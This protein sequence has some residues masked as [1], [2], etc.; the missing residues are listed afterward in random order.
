[1]LTDAGI[2]RESLWIDNV[3]PF[4]PPQ[5]DMTYCPKEALETYAQELR[6]RLASLPNLNLVVPMGNTALE[7]LTDKTTISKWRGSLL[8]TCLETSLVALVGPTTRQTKVLPTYH[9]SY[10]FRDPSAMGQAIHDWKRVREE[11]GKPKPVHP[12]MPREFIIYPQQ[13]DLDYLIDACEGSSL[14]SIDIE[15]NMNTREIIC[16]GIAPSPTLACCIPWQRKFFPVIRRIL[17]SPTPKTGHN[18]ALFDNFW[19]TWFGFPVNNLTLDTMFLHHCL[20]PGEGHSLATIASLYTHEIYWKDDA[21]DAKEGTSKKVFAPSEATYLYNCLIPETKVLTGD[22]RWIP[23]GDIQEG[24]ELVGLEEIPSGPQKPRKLKPAYVTRV[25]RRTAEVFCITCE[26]GRKVYATSEHPWLSRNKNWSKARQQWRKTEELKIG[27][28]LTFLADPWETAQDYDS[29]WLAGIL[30]GE[31]SVNEYCVQ[32]AQKQG[33]VLERVKNLLKRKG[34]YYTISHNKESD[35]CAYLMTSLR[36]GMRLLGTLR[37]TR[38]LSKHKRLWVNKSPFQGALGYKVESVESVGEKEVVSIT[39]T[40][41]TFIA[42]G[43]FTHN[44]RDA[45]VTHEIAGLLEAQARRE[46]KWEFYQRHYQAIFPACLATMLGGIRV[47]GERAAE[48]FAE[49]TTRLKEI[50]GQLETLAGKSLIGKKAL[51]NKKKAEFLYDTLKLPKKWTKGDNLSGEKSLA[52]D[53]KTL[54]RLMNANPIALGESGPLLL[55]HARLRQ[56]ST[57]FSPTRIETEMKPGEEGEGRFFFTLK[58]STKTGRLASSKSPFRIGA[59]AQNVDRECKEI[60]LPE[61][62]QLMLELDASQIESRICYM[63]TREP[64]LVKLANTKPWEYD[65]HKE[66]AARIFGILVEA[67]TKEQRHTAKISVH[68]AQRAGTG[69]TLQETILKETGVLRPEKECQALIDSYYKA[70]PG[71]QKFFREVRSQ[72]VTT[73]KI[74]NLWGRTLDFKWERFGEDMFRQA[75]SFEMQSDA[76][77]WLNT[78]GLIPLHDFLTQ[79]HKQSRLLAQVHDSLLLSLAPQEGWEILNFL[80]PLLE[81]PVMYPAGPLSI[82]MEITLGRNWG[83]KA[84]TW[85]KTPTQEEL[86]NACRALNPL[87]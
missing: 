3:C 25:G 87:T 10:L 28:S 46:G 30:D 36:Q 70:F 47:D 75:Y 86:E 20:D 13:E 53:E 77:D 61:R 85:K 63:L 65:A 15:A 67:V 35:V 34:F 14:I 1:M 9:P 57:F 22:L 26:G 27:E 74:T 51:S 69:K 55:E 4:R 64:E 73:R 31:G 58:P 24:D 23:I 21:I 19:L 41:A 78:R 5:N 76:A 72:V 79:T 17:E 56:L 82:P 37:P 39:T 12:P 66:N 62:G 48:K 32:I 38:L 60:Y 59:G 2:P 11:E 44:C 40:T 18:A 45:A 29:G 71:I 83:E 43:F 80:L 16:V 8:S 84:F 52:T 33:K 49:L 42:E 6:A 50:E 7:A 81:A 54:R 68:A